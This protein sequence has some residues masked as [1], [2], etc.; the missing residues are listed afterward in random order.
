MLPPP[1]A[2]HWQLSWYF[3]RLQHRVDDLTN[4]DAFHLELWPQQ[5]AVLQNR[6]CQC[7]YVFGRHEIALLESRERP[8]RRQ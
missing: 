7:F 1:C 8:R 3:D 2:T 5:H 6:G 4:L